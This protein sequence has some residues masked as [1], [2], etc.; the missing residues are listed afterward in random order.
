MN[1]GTE[2]KE[3]FRSGI[4]NAGKEKHPDHSSLGK[5]L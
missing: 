5:N 1:R 2:E 4:K 3:A